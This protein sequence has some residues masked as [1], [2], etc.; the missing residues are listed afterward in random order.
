MWATAWTAW[1]RPET[2]QAPHS[3]VRVR[4]PSTPGVTGSPKS[5]A[6]ILRC[7]SLLVTR[8]LLPTRAEVPLPESAVTGH[9][10]KQR[11][12]AGRGGSGGCVNRSHFFHQLYFLFQ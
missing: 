8:R 6:R 2:R 7:V 5:V 1:W 9:H 10:Q 4:S 12:G 11:A 3:L